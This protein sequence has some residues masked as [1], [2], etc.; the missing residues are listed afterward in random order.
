MAVTPTTSPH[1]SHYDLVS[2]AIATAAATMLTLLTTLGSTNGSIESSVFLRAL[3]EVQ[4]L[5][6]EL[7]LMVGVFALLRRDEH[8]KRRLTFASAALLIVGTLLL[9]LSATVLIASG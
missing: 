4:L 7:A 8:Q 2:A 3:L 6:L 1:E 5:V 9:W